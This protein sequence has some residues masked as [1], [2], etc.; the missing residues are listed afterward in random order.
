MMFGWDRLFCF[1]RHTGVL[2]V[3]LAQSSC[4]PTFL[5]PGDKTIPEPGLV[6][7]A[8]GLPM[9]PRPLP[10]RPPG[11]G[12]TALSPG[13][14]LIPERPGEVW[15]GVL[16]ILLRHYNVQTVNQESG[17]ITTEWDRFYLNQKVYRNKISLRVVNGPYQQT[18]LM[19]VNNV[20]VL[21]DGAD[22]GS[23]SPVWLPS[24][25]TSQESERLVRSL[26]AWLRISPPVNPVARSDKSDSG[27]GTWR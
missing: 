20:E 24:K 15:N 21:Q 7:G 11:K 18:H 17:V 4:T 6:G 27:K 13:A 9:S 2:G 16:N 10:L 8:A 23:L 19:V 5:R 26:A 22:A 3:V 1:I 12:I 14:W 25:D